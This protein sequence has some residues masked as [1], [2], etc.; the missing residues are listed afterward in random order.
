MGS[1]VK[2]Q[3]R[4]RA[5]ATSIWFKLTVAVGIIALLVY[6]NRI[7]ISVLTSLS[8][9]WPWLLAAFFLALPPFCIVAYRFRLIL[10][11]QGICVPFAQA[12][13]WTMVGSFF[14]LA[15]PSSNGGDLGVWAPEVFQ[16]AQL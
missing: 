16:Q 5:V 11:S 6:F 14:D 10:I 9:T 13:R 8:E 4:L 12:L 2:Q 1:A 7:D 15:M 3:S